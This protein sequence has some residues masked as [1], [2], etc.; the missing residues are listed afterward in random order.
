MSIF[1]VMNRIWARA[2][3]CFGGDRAFPVV[4]RVYGVAPMAAAAAAAA[5]V[6][7]S[8][9][10]GGKQQNQPQQ[11]GAGGRTEQ[12][13]PCGLIEYIEGSHNIKKIKAVVAAAIEE[14]E[15]QVRLR[16]LQQLNRSKH[17]NKN[18]DKNKKEKPSRQQEQTAAEEEEQQEEEGEEAAAGLSVREEARRTVLSR[19][20]ASGAGAYMASFLLGVGDRH[21]E[22]ILVAPDASL[23]H[24]DFGYALGSR[25]LGVLGT[26]DLDTAD[27]AITPGFK[28]VLSSQAA[29][30]PPPV[31]QAAPAAPAAVATAAASSSGSSSSQAGPGG[32]ST[33]AAQAAASG[34]C[35]RGGPRATSSAPKLLRVPGYPLQ[36]ASSSCSSSAA[37]SSS[38][39]TE[40]SSKQDSGEGGE[41]DSKDVERSAALGLM[42][43][44]LDRTRSARRKSGSKSLLSRAAAG[45]GLKKSSKSEKADSSKRTWTYWDSFVELCVQS[46][47]EL[48]RQR[49]VLLELVRVV[50][51]SRRELACWEPG[52][53]ELGPGG[54]GGPVCQ[55]GGVC[56]AGAALQ[57]RS[58]E[59]KAHSHQLS[60][61]LSL[62][63]SVCVCVLCVCV[64]VCVVCVCV[65]FVCVVCVCV[66]VCSVC[67]CSVCV[68]VCMCVQCLCV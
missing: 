66:C 7:G 6:G 22:N 51:A 11:Q 1:A 18:K 49:H 46:Y 64:C 59:T 25:V 15:R 68:C 32:P 34:K 67:V 33:T 37:S 56:G 41:E 61:S 47:L 38:S 63:L 2:K 30:P 44:G 19:L 54:G 65:V 39:S 20:V 23:F 55:P 24:I 52:P 62:S 42:V 35:P 4:A 13:P 21:Y 12:L 28:E 29:P 17:K 10:G 45:T 40:N 8:Q 43:G 53:L 31:Q 48:Y 9:V 57:G 3:L 27:L 16:R 36:Q 60:L 14:Q 26:L 50:F 58:A 5:A